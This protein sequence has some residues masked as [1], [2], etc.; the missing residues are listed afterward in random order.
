MVSGYD[1]GGDAAHEAYGIT[2]VPTIVTI[3]PNDT[4]YTETHLGFYNVLNAAGIETKEVC[5]IPMEVDLNIIP[6]SG[7]NVYNAQL[8]VSI[9]GGVSP[10]NIKWMS[11][12]GALLSNEP[13]IDGVAPGVYQVSVIDA[14]SNPVE[15][16]TNVEVGYEGQIL[17]E[18]DFESYEPFTDIV[19][20]T[21]AW[22][23]MCDVDISSSYTSIFSKWRKLM[24]VFMD[25]L[26][27]I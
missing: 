25:L 5:T 11:Q 21:N 18:D 17:I 23:T 20:Q 6:A 22:Q 10:F 26:R 24:F 16:V 27:C 2:G 8:G 14:S 7:S 9:L 3:N 13:T 12:T 15:F 4:S 19:S 1:G